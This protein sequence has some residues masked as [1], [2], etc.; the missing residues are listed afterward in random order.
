[1][2]KM[3]FLG[4]FLA[5]SLTSLS[6]ASNK[7]ELPE[8][9]PYHSEWQGADVGDT[10]QL[11]D[12]RQLWIFGDTF[13]GPSRKNSTFLNNSVAISDC[14]SGKFKIE[15]FWKQRQTKEGLVP[16]SVFTGDYEKQRLPSEIDG[17]YPH[18]KGA[19]AFYWPLSFFMANHQ[20]YVMLLRTVYDKSTVL[21]FREM[22]VD[23]AKITDWEKPFAQWKI[24]YSQL[25]DSLK[26][27]PA[28][29]VLVQGDYAYIYSFLSENHA[30]QKNALS[31]IKTSDLK[32][33][34]LRNHLE[35]LHVDGR[36]TKL[37]KK[38][39]SHEKLKIV[40]Q[41]GNTEFS[42]YYDKAKK[43]WTALQMIR[44]R[45]L[46]LIAVREDPT[47]E[48]KMK[49]DQIAVQYAPTLMG[50]WSEP[51]IIHTVEETTVGHKLFRVNN[52]CYAAKA[53]TE[54]Q[55]SASAD[56]S[57]KSSTK[58]WIT[59]VCN[60]MNVPLV[61]QQMEIYRPRTLPSN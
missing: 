15:Y 39:N 61:Y 56:G 57:G 21:G 54:Y 52:F 36:W 53:H 38:K 50:P 41:Q 20:V 28:A 10:L 4:F 31:R 34:D 45:A 42:I 46:E 44:N 17:E 7:C 1:M 11:P 8:S 30:L 3:S 33:S 47:H 5:L 58:P 6:L 40:L 49:P 9:L 25:S 18:N 12:G 60:T 26:V 27:F 35:Y 23:V 32:K 19:K 48:Q 59:Y 29:K 37:G 51:K 2:R 55:V 43:R 14:K 13:V 16:A 22:G 24:E